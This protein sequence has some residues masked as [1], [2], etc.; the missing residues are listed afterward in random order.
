MSSAAQQ[1]KGGKKKK[2][3]ALESR[4][5]RQSSPTNSVQAP[6]L[7]IGAEQSRA[8]TKQVLCNQQLAVACDELQ[9]QPELS[10]LHA[11]TNTHKL[12]TA[13]ATHTHTHTHTHI[14]IC[15]L[16]PTNK[17]HFH[18][19]TPANTHWTVLIWRHNIFRFISP[20]SPHLCPAPPLLSSLSLCTITGL[21]A[22]LPLIPL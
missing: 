22:F 2:K 21:F 16:G 12:N 6:G 4:R 20:P 10:L 15:T 11:N 17:T 9:S 3:T 18:S 13:S 19:A 14:H 1:P 7:I 5:V 8:R